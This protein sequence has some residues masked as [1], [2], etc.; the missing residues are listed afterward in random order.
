MEC[1]TGEGDVEND[2]FQVCVSVTAIY[3]V[4]VYCDDNILEDVLEA[5]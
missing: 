4:F 5:I 3:A 2:N 1:E